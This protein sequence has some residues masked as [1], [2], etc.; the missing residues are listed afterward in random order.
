MS[1]LLINQPPLQ[2]LPDLAMKIGLNEA[3]ILQ[4]LHYWI[5]R[6]VNIREDHKWVYNDYSTWQEQF[7][8]WSESTIKRAFLTLEKLG[9]VVSKQ[10]EKY[11]SDYKKRNRRKWYT[12]DYVAFEKLEKEEIPLTPPPIPE[13]VNLTRS[14]IPEEV[15]LTRS[16]EEVNLARSTYTETTPESTLNW[17]VDDWPLIKVLGDEG[18]DP[19]TDS[20]ITVGRIAKD[21]HVSPDQL[22][23]TLQELNKQKTFINNPFGWVR[24]KLRELKA[25]DELYFQRIQRVDYKGIKN[26]VKNKP[27]HKAT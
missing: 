25:R 27:R 8:F 22:R 14:E 18:Y 11:T 10:F 20:A 3:I 1:K 2:V 12:I 13:E 16:I 5:E 4:Q 7:P 21:E 23:E 24:T 9:I 15:N 26:N 19:D 17:T 6:S